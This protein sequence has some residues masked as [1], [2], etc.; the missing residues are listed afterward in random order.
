MAFLFKS[1]KH[2][3]N[4]LPPA[5]REITSSHGQPASTPTSLNG[6]AAAKDQEKNKGGQTPPSGNSVNNSLNSLN[7]A[8]PTSPD[9]KQRERSESEPPVSYSCETVRFAQYTLGL[10]GFEMT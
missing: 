2:Q 7:E 6:V 9:P 5:S 4:A 3:N 8:R 1:K 10:Q